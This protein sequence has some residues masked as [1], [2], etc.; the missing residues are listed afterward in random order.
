[1]LKTVEFLVGK[2]KLRLVV[3][4]AVKGGKLRV[5]W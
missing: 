1:M 5:I 2:A 4:S 3:S